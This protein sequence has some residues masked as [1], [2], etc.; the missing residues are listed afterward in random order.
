MA[1][2]L[3]PVDVAVIGLG[4]AGA[5]ALRGAKITANLAFRD[6]AQLNGLCAVR[7]GLQQAPAAGGRG[8]IADGDA[9]GRG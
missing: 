3:K 9:L 8:V 4:T 2:K 1:I 6:G 7:E 5:I